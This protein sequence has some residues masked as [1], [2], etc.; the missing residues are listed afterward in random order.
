MGKIAKIVPF[1]Y[2]DWKRMEKNAKIVPFFYKGWKRTQRSFRS[3]EN[4][5]KMTNLAQKNVKWCVLGTVLIN[6]RSFGS[7]KTGS[8]KTLILSEN[9]ILVVQQHSPLTILKSKLK[10]ALNFFYHSFNLSKESPKIGF[11][12]QEQLA[13]CFEQFPLY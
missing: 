3:F 8:L 1:F 4:P 11:S 2:K 12:C 5:A 9:G 13:V 7:V 10:K 6:Y